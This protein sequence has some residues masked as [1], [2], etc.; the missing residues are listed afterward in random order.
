MS[1]SEKL[2]EYRSQCESFSDC[3]LDGDEF[4]ATAAATFLRTVDELGRMPILTPEDAEA[5]LDFIVTEL[6]DGAT[7]E[8]VSPVPE[9]LRVYLRGQSGST[10]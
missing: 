5:A 9:S 1:S 10:H 7:L 6:A 2:A 4:D 3:D 8:F